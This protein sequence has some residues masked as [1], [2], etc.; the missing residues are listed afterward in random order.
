MSA[1]KDIRALAA[2]GAICL[3]AA[4]G[5]IYARNTLE[6]D[7]AHTNEVSFPSVEVRPYDVKLKDSP[8]APPTEDMAVSL[9]GETFRLGEARGIVFESDKEGIGR[10]EMQIQAD[11]ADADKIT[12]LHA[13]GRSVSFDG[14]ALRISGL[15]PESQY[16][17]N[18]TIGLYG[19]STQATARDPDH[20]N[21]QKSFWFNPEPQHM[22]CGGDCVLLLEQPH[23]M[24]IG[25]AGSRER[26]IT[27]IIGNQT[28]TKIGLLALGLFLGASGLAYG[29]RFGARKGIEALAPTRGNLRID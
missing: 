8:K 15:R 17:L 16:M 5:M 26:E 28:K 21:S 4:L 1:K 7:M 25:P 18:A 11:P 20:A 2:F 24:S 29:L 12:L 9:S 19:Y 22:N 6:L 14:K 10:L 23:L 27:E 13:L 3:G